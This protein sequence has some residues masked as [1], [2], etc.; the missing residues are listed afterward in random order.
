MLFAMSEQRFEVHI[1][2]YALSDLSSAPKPFFLNDV[3]GDRQ[4]FS[5]IATYEC[6]NLQIAWG[7]FEQACHW[8]EEQLNK[9][10]SFGVHVKLEEVVHALDINIPMHHPPSPSHREN[11]MVESPLA[12]AWDIHVDG[13]FDPAI[14]NA[15]QDQGYIPLQYRSRQGQEMTTMTLHF[16]R[17]SDAENEFKRVRSFLEGTGGFH[18]TLYYEHP[19]AFVVYGKTQPRPIVMMRN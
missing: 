14:K 12:A 4:V 9:Q 13:V 8:S 1:V 7:V 2:G 5:S 16:L 11:T 15:L 18:G 17:L 19:L 10:A 6:E 3:L